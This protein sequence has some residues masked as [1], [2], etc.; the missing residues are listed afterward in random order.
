[1]DVLAEE[2]GHDRAVVLLLGGG[3][4]VFLLFQFMAHVRWFG[5]FFSRMFPGMQAESLQALSDKAGGFLWLGVMP[6]LLFAWVFPL[7]R[8]D[9][10]GGPV[11][12][13]EWWW[14][15][16]LAPWPVLLAFW[17]AG[18]IRHQERYP[19]VREAIWSMRLLRV[20]LGMWAL[21]LLGYEAFF[22]GMM[23]FGL[24]EQGVSPW[25]AIAINTVFYSLAHL[26]KGRGE[27]FGAIPL[28]I[29]LCLAA[30]D[31]GNFRV[32]F[33]VHL[34]MAWSNELFTLRCHKSIRSPLN[35]GMP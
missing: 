19:Q 28:G 12:V 22:R 3:L 4:L 17:N 2:W 23:L 1:M 35:T 26:P 14:F 8:L 27:A 10:L 7:Y 20:D 24:L 9:W 6:V 29:L 18:N 32:P 30:L 5:P 33:A 25:I 11:G 31:T 16:G 15:L 34:V 13:A 21:Y